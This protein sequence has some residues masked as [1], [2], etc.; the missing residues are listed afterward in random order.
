MKTAAVKETTALRNGVEMPLVG[1]GVMNMYGSECVRAICEA[2]EA[3]YR[4]IDT[5]AI[6]GNEG[7]VGRGI[8]E[9]DADRDEL[10]VT[11]KL[12]VQDASYEH[13][14]Q[15]C[16][17]SLKNL[18]LDYLDLYLIHQPLGDIYG[19]WRAM[20]ELLDEGKVRAIGVSNLNIGRLVDLSMHNRITP[21]VCQVEIHP[22]YQQTKAIQE[23]KN[24]GIQ[25]EGWAPF[26]E[27]RNDIF[28][29]KLL[30]SIGEK[31]GKTP[32]QIILRWDVQRGVAVIPKS[33]HPARIH[34]N[35]DIW[36]FELTAGEMKQISSMDK[37]RELFFEHDS[38]EMARMFGSYHIH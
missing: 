36:D 21:H 5:A 30:T 18:G 23:M 26:A 12:W 20:E 32:A 9:S 34:E 3:G 17:T 10:F 27:G 1:L 7:A 16:E 8:R 37:G 38:A 35:Y 15:A 33:S 6:Y 11:T 22:F 29:D 2:V 31:Y 13:A 25:P 4:M 19:A 28:H 14:K 24:L